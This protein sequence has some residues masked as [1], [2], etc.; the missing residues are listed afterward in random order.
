MIPRHPKWSCQS[1]PLNYPKRTLPIPAETFGTVFKVKVGPDA[2]GDSQGVLTSRFWICYQDAGKVYIRSAIDGEDWSAPIELFE[3][4]EQI[5]K[6]DFSFDQLGR[7][8]VFY[9]VGTELRLWFFDS[10]A[11]PPAFVKEVLIAD[12]DWPTINFDIIDNTSNPASDVILCYVKNERI[13]QRIQRDRFD[14]EYSTPATGQGIKIISSGMTEQ[15]RFQI[16]Y[17]YQDPRDGRLSDKVY[18][19]SSSIFKQLQYN[20]LEIGFTIA[21]SPTDCELKKINAESIFVE[22]M[23]TIAANFGEINASSVITNEQSLC[24]RFLVSKITDQ[25][26]VQILRDPMPDGVYYQEWFDEFIFSGGDYILRMTQVSDSP[27]SPTKRVELI[28]DSVTLIDEV[29][30]D[31]ESRTG[32][33]T[34]PTGANKLR[35]GAYALA[36]F[37]GEAVYSDSYPAQFLNMYAIFNGDRI[38]WPLSSG[39]SGIESSPAGNPMVVKFRASKDPNWQFFKRL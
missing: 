11:L 14:I 36:S 20:D 25:I 23:F 27:T 35:F 3:E 19:T 24:L 34:E 1:K 32:S 21:D 29:V 9:Q 8:L 18:E 30:P 31:L 16:I 33:L 2:I 10:S 7:E 39:V 15:N 26:L 5:E 6:L 28:R 4:T 22:S 17:N 38:D 37:P 12:G 13:Y